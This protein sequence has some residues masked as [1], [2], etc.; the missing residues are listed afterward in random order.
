MVSINDIILNISQNSKRESYDHN[1]T[2]N[3]YKEIYESLEGYELLNPL[4]LKF[5]KGDIIRY[6]NKLDKLSCGSLIIDIKYHEDLITMKPN[7][8]LI[9][10]ITLQSI[11]AKGKKGPNGVIQSNKYWNIV[12]LQYYIFKFKEPLRKEEKRAKRNIEVV[13]KLETK[14]RDN[15]KNKKTTDVSVSKVTKMKMLLHDNPNADVD[16]NIVVEKKEKKKK[17]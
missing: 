1:K 12:P 10:R 15:M 6:S 8:D 5:N 7:N 9:D 2:E 11:E 3:V 16:N 14:I 17:K 4:S 13:K